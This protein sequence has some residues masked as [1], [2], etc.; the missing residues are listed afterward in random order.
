MFHTGRRA[1]KSICMSGSNA[2]TYSSVKPE[3]PKSMDG[4]WVD[5]AGPFGSLLQKIGFQ[6]T[7]VSNGHGHQDKL[8]ND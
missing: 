1:K 7:L 5:V 4:T 3:Q 8:A 2:E 6:P